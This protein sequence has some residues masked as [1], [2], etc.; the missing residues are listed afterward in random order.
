MRHFNR[1]HTMRPKS[2]GRCRG[3]RSAIRYG[4]ADRAGEPSVLFA[5]DRYIAAAASAICP[6][7]AC[8]PLTISVRARCWRSAGRMPRGICRAWSAWL[9]GAGDHDPG[10][11][12]RS[13]P[14]SEEPLA[15]H[16]ERGSGLLLCSDAPSTS[17]SEGHAA[18]PARR[19][20]ACGLR[21]SPRECDRRPANQ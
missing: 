15:L 5:S 16:A 20:C 3:R 1:R 14:G 4:R 12:F 18:A 19:P 6:P 11:D 8:P 2:C 7:G 13:L 10:R 9:A 17:T 21:L